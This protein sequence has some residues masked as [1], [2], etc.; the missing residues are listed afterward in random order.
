MIPGPKSA[1]EDD[2]MRAVRCHIE[3][4]VDVMMMYNYEP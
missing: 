2:T 4:K 3:D 1:D